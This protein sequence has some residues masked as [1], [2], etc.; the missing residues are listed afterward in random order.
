M[1]IPSC[2][3]TERLCRHWTTYNSI[4]SNYYDP[5]VDDPTDVS[6]FPVSDITRNGGGASSYHEYWWFGALGNG[7]DIA[8]GD[9]HFRIAALNPFGDRRVSSDW[10][11]WV[12]GMPDIVTVNRT[13][14][15]IVV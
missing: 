13:T 2:C 7:S 12:D 1:G 5:N 15:D 3:W 9:Y 10:S 4:T 8:N 11:I 6:A 14:T